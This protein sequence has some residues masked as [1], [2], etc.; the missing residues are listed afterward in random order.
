MRP[1]F[2]WCER[3]G[4]MLAAIRPFD[5]GARVKDLQ[6]KHGAPGVK[7][8]LAAIRVLFDWLVVGQVVPMKS[9]GDGAWAEGCGKDRQDPCAGRGRLAQARRQYSDR[10]RARSV[11]PGAHRHPHLFLRTHRRGA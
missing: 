8:Q 9:G 4:L 2:A 6:E 10:H 5:V 7:Q 3:R 11:R 1:F